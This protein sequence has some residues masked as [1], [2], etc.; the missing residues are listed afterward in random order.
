MTSSWFFLYTLF[1]NSLHL[2]P[3]GLYS[4]SDGELNTSLLFFLT[5][6]VHHYPR[7]LFFVT[8]DYCSSLPTTTPLCMWVVGCVSFVYVISSHSKWQQIAI[9]HNNLT[10]EEELLLSPSVSV[11]QTVILRVLSL[12]TPSTIPLLPLKTFNLYT[13]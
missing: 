13:S 9:S 5:T 10:Y 4:T 7:L 12:P 3:P 8:H 11:Y 2:K 1:I 6:T